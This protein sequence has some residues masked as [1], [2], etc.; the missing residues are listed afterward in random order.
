[1]I[2][3][4]P[5]RAITFLD[6]HDTG[7]TLNHWPYPGRNL[8]EGYAYLLTHPGRC[9]YPRSPA[10]CSRTR[11]LCSTQVLACRATARAPSREVV[12]GA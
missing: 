5:S 7:S 1:V 6:N 12:S 4:W 2:G 3:L 8:P 10:R 11:V 9:C